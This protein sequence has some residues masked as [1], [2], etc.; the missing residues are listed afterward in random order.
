MVQ[1]R[2][3]E[4]MCVQYLIITPMANCHWRHSQT[5]ISHV[6]LPVNGLIHFKPE[7]RNPMSK[8]ALPIAELKPALT[9]LGKIIG[10]RMTLPVLSH[11]RI[12]RTTDGWIALS[13]TDLDHCVTVRLEQPNEGEALSLLVPYD[14]LVKVSKNCPK[15]D[16]V[17]I[18]TGEKA[19]E[20]SVTI[21]YAIG[22]QVAEVKVD[23]LPVEE[24]PPI[25]RIKGESI[26]LNDA[27]R[28]SIHEAMQCASVD[29]TRLILNGAFIDV[30]R[31]DAHYII[32]TD[33]RH[34]YASNSFSLPLEDSLIIPAHKF[35]GWK[36]FSHDG[37]WKLKVGTK[38]KEDELPPIQI[39]SRR[40]RFITRQFEGNYPNWRQVIPTAFNTSVDFDPQAVEQIIKTI[41]RMPDHDV[42]NHSL[43]IEV[44]G[45]KVNLLC[46]TG[47][48][49]PW[50]PVEV[51]SGDIKGPDVT[52]HLNRHSLFKALEFG[53]LRLDIID[54][55]SAM[56][57]S[58]EGRQLIVMPVRPPAPPPA[59]KPTPVPESDGKG[60]AEPVEPHQPAA[61]STAAPQERKPMPKTSTPATNGNGGNGEHTE[62]TTLEKAVDQIETVKG[63][64]REAIRG[65]NELADTLKQ[66]H[67]DQKASERDVQ[68]VRTTLEKLQSVKL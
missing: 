49:Q 48:D 67:R 55:M 10:K 34:L 19:S 66:V 39:S 47:L 13:A 64:Y 18:G 59:E 3:S 7:R 65:L 57:F 12:K 16:S 31:K 28:T 35:I 46:K 60:E 38:E 43:G 58:Q 17:L 68:S 6:P 26:P 37:E 53:L 63:S 33:G 56:R 30:S 52:T 2:N 20:S 22:N 15:S 62:K 11:V 14:E 51:P 40:W 50:M 61:P 4:F 45:K 36:E 5:T 23:T 29:E 1:T 42:V 25:P 8:I 27:L 41:Q 21:Q 54:S 24:F 32:G 44:K 9:G